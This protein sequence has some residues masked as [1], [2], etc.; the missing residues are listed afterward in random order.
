[1]EVVAKSLDEITSEVCDVYDAL[2]APKR[3]WRDNNN[4]L[5]LFFRACSA[6]V[7]LILDA[8]LAL[9]GRYNPQHCSDDDLSA[10]AKLVGTAFRQG[11]GSALRITVANTSDIDVKT[12]MAGAYSYQSVSGMAFLF[13]LLSDRELVP[14]AFNAVTAVSSEKGSYAVG[15]NASITV[16]RVDG[17][18]IDGAFKF[19]CEDNSG[20]LGYPDE[21]AVEFRS[22]VL[23]DVNRQ[24]AIKELELKIRNLPN[25]FEC[26]LRFN[27]GV[28]PVVYDGIVLAPLEL[29][30]T[31]TGTPSDDLAKAVAE[32]VMYSTHKVDP[33]NV[34]HYHNDLYVGGK[35][36]VY[37]RYHGKSEFTLEIVHQ[38]DSRK[39]SGGQ[40]EAEFNRLLSV[41][42]N[43]V[44]HVDRIT[45]RDIYNRL[46]EAGLPSVTALDVNIFVDGDPVSYLEVPATRVPHLAGVVYVGV[47]ISGSA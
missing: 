3:I 8:V 35:Y 9:R 19:S 26:G 41:Y 47:D 6:G 7:K 24:D 10:T 13:T 29:L 36:P 43:A 33:A 22:R 28:L 45:E 23:N 2:I 37:F 18:P 20:S 4:K 46:A 16:T 27:P 40:V 30:I 34:V 15:D 38:Y 14:G 5:Y 32:S 42:K 21:S 31:I 12:L 17:A 25:I 1:M 39:H 44:T 11:S